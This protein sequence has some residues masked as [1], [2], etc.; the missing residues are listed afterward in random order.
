MATRAARGFGQY[1]GVARAIERVGERWALLIVRDLLT[2]P[3]RYGDL[4]TALPR[5]PTNILADRLKELQESGVIRRVPTVRGGYELTALGRELA[6]VVAGL[7][8][9]GWSSLGEPAEGET[10]TREALIT[11]LRAAFRADGAAGTPP[12]RYVLHVAEA[13]VS[14]VVAG[15]ALDVVPIGPGALPQP[16]RERP[17]PAVEASV[18][19]ALEPTEFRDLLAG[20]L[21]PGAVRVLAGEATSVGHFVQTFRIEPIAGA[22]GAAADGAG[23]ASASEAGGSAASVT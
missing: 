22:A 21:G 19:L 7:E 12:T 14:A 13:S 16:R 2:G 1:D 8:R 11:A 17:E 23:T 5:I 10:V 4:K 9:W 6:P 20:R 15:G 3:H 18:E